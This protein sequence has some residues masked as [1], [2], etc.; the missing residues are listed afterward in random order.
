MTVLGTKRSFLGTGSK[1]KVVLS[2]VE[3]RIK[4]RII[5]YLKVFKIQ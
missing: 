2:S 3:K 4:I 1:I 5:P